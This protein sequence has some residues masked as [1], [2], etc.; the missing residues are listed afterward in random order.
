MTFYS[1][2][3]EYVLCTYS[4]P[5][6][7][8]PW[9]IQNYSKNPLPALFHNSRLAHDVIPSIPYI[10]TFFF[11]SLHVLLNPHVYLFTYMRYMRKGLQILLS[12]HVLELY[13]KRQVCFMETLAIPR[14]SE[15]LEIPRPSGHTADCH[16]WPS[17]VTD[18][19]VPSRYQAN[20][21]WCHLN[22]IPRGFLGIKPD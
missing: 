14:S 7:K 2:S 19:V 5:E 16:L 22:L 12:L 9:Q 3:I 6:T 15:H 17:L 4:P 13:P 20:R 10:Q 1:R 21:S 11:F 8:S 18:F